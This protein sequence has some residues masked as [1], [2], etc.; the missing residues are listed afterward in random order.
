MAVCESKVVGSIHEPSRMK[1]YNGEA[2]RGQGLQGLDCPDLSCVRMQ[3]PVVKISV[4]VSH[5]A[6]P[7]CGQMT[8]AAVSPACRHKTIIRMRSGE[9]DAAVD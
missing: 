4:P 6:V 1:R 8:V 3:L 5:S 9:S 2:E 7:V